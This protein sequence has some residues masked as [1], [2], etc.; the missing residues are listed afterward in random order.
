VD[1]WR[2]EVYG[3][4]VDSVRPTPRFVFSPRTGP[5][6]LASILAIAGPIDSETGAPVDD[7]PLSLA[8]F[9][10]AP[11]V[12][13][14]KSPGGSAFKRAPINPDEPAFPDLEHVVPGSDVVGLTSGMPVIGDPGVPVVKPAPAAPVTKGSAAIEGPADT[15]AF[16]RFVKARAKAGKW[17]D[18]EFV[19]TDAL[20]AHRLNQAGRIVVCKAAGQIVAAGLCV[21]AA[22]TG[23]VL[24]LQ[25]SLDETDPAAGSWEF[26]GGCLEQDEIPQDAAEREWGEETGLVLPGAGVI[27]GSWTSPNGVYAG[28][29]YAIR[30]E[31][32][33]PILDG[34]I[35]GV[36]PDDPDG[37]ATEALAWWMPADMV[38]NPVIRTE[39]AADMVAVIDCLA[40]SGLVKSSEWDTHP[41]RK[42][43][44]RLGEAH[45]GPVQAALAGSV[46]AAQ[47]RALAQKYMAAQSDA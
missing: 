9:E 10:G 13:A 6:P 1:E 28:F 7:L 11:G 41:V 4:P 14:D 25:R 3:L 19:D 29:V 37:D 33:L 40:G 21:Q 22:D 8:P 17:R 15:A 26:P 32:E 16:R 30:S 36:N 23:R 42:V 38:D 27:T 31:D 20:T 2:Q 43:E 47:L 34:R 35:E 44:D 46:S 39:L 12:L 18:F 45:S 5:V 24:M